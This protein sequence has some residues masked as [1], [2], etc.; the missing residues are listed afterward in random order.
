[1]DMR[2][3]KLWPFFT[4]LNEVIMVYFDDMLTHK[5]MVYYS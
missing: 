1:M 5:Q 2:V 4:T 3:S